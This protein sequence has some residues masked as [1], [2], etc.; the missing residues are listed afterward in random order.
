MALAFV[1]AITVSSIGIWSPLVLIP[2]GFLE[3]R[4]T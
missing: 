2:A 1:I 4:F 3:N